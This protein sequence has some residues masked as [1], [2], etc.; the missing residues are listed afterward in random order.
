MKVLDQHEIKRFLGE[1][2]L[3]GDDAILERGAGTAA[4]VA[5]RARCHEQ[6]EDK[7]DH[8]PYIPR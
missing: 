7:R 4:H 1:N 3:V 6:Q 2:S 5:G 8:P